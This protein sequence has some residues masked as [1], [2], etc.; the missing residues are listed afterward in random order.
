MAI[1]ASKNTKL[2]KE[3]EALNAFVATNRN[4][5]YESPLQETVTK[6]QIKTPS[7][8]TVKYGI[9]TLARMREREAQNKAQEISRNERFNK[10]LAS[11]EQNVAN[12]LK[13]R[14]EDEL[15]SRGFTPP[16]TRQEQEAIDRARMD[17]FRVVSEA[18]NLA[19]EKLNTSQKDYKFYNSLAA[20]AMASGNAKQAEDLMRAAQATGGSIKNYS[21]RSKFLEDQ[22]MSKAKALISEKTKARIAKMQTQNTSNPEASSFIFKSTNAPIGVGID[23]LSYE[24]PYKKPLEATEQ[25]FGLVAPRRKDYGVDFSSISEYN[26]AQSNTSEFTSKKAVQG[27]AENVNLPATFPRYTEENQFPGISKIPRVEINPDESES[28]YNARVLQEY[29]KNVIIP[30]FD[31]ETQEAVTSAIELNKIEPSLFRKRLSSPENLK[32]HTKVSTKLKSDRKVIVQ[33]MKELK[34]KLRNYNKYPANSKERALLENQIG[35]LNEQLGF[36]DS[37]LN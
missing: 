18:R 1:A 10:S 14:Y 9:D 27:N 15:A 13:K 23:S 19:K 16:K 29:N 35:V 2:S 11:M 21:A 12:T 4:P 20:Q 37:L 8:G 36:F 5:E 31:K 33:T 30:S 7:K 26:P 34:S 24:L 32:E 6:T 28:Q 17:E 3:Q 25:P 22:E